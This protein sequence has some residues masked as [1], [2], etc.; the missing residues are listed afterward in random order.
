MLLDVVRE[1]PCSVR[2]LDIGSPQDLVVRSDVVYC[3]ALFN[4]EGQELVELCTTLLNSHLVQLQQL[5]VGR[6]LA[7]GHESDDGVRTEHRRMKGE[8]AKQASTNDSVRQTWVRPW[9]CPIQYVQVN[10]C[11]RND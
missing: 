5:W 3:F 7:T 10:E 4:K 9:R 11:I 1:S 2:M 6:R 8:S